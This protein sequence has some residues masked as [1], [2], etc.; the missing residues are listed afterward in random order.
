[1]AEVLTLEIAKEYQRRAGL[2]ADNSLQDTGERLGLRKELQ[3]RCNLTE[4]QAL[5][6]INGFH[7]K[8]YILIA[9]RKERENERDAGGE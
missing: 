3:K 6:I 5:N 1:M 2:I 9:E 8:D 4:L 7:V